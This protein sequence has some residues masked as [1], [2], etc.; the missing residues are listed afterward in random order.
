MITI[1][2][3]KEELKR[4]KIKGITGKNKAELID[5]LPADHAYRGKTK[6]RAPARSATPA[7]P[8]PPPKK[9]TAPTAPLPRDD[10]NKNE[11]ERKIALAKKELSKEQTAKQKAFLNKKLKK[12][13]DLLAKQSPPPAPKKTVKVKRSKPKAV[14]APTAPSAAEQ[15]MFNPDLM[16]LIGGFK[17]DTE[18]SDVIK[19][20]VRD[21]DFLWGET[22][23]EGKSAY[24]DDFLAEII[25]D[26]KA[27]KNP[28]KSEIQYCGESYGGEGSYVA[29]FYVLLTQIFDKM[30]INYDKVEKDYN[31]DN[32]SVVKRSEFLEEHYT[33]IWDYLQDEWGNPEDI[34]EEMDNY[35]DN[36]IYN[37]LDSYYSLQ[38]IVKYKDETER[39]YALSVMELI[40]F[41]CEKDFDKKLN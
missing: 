11:L 36:R 21:A 37:P 24:Y 18:M 14:A 16:R 38:L 27:K 17:K 22:G 26:L 12:Y 33:N 30:K 25:D 6:G 23:D 5:M 35:E 2:D 31:L 9:T 19:K 8:P 10:Y 39:K 41:W 20:Q 15:V 7:P 29:Q 28:A 34:S 32:Y 40:K 1:K 4:L 13:E 3:I